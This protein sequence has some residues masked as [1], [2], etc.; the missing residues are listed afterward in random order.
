MPTKQFAS[1]ASPGKMKWTTEAERDLLLLLV[2]M[3]VTKI[4]YQEVARRMG[5]VSVEGVSRHI[6]RIRKDPNLKGITVAKGV[7]RESMDFECEEGEMK[8]EDS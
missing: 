8:M 4:D 1:P 3:Y 2:Q 7:K 5:G 6:R